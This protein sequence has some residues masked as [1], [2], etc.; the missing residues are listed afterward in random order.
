MRTM[1][2]REGFS[3]GQV[4]EYQDYTRCWIR[5]TVQAVDAPETTLE[6][7]GETVVERK[8]GAVHILINDPF[9]RKPRIVR[10]NPKRVRAVNGTD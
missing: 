7:P 9:G 5:G 8:E 3:K 4:V 10:I 6:G 2:R 1:I